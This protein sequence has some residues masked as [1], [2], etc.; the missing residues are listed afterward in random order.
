MLSQIERR[1]WQTYTD[2][3]KVSIVEICKFRLSIGYEEIENAR[4]DADAETE[5][6]KWTR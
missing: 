5:R 6:G 4:R 3:R 1:D 2:V